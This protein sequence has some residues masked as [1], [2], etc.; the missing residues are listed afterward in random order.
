MNNTTTLLLGT[1]IALGLSSCGDQPAASAPSSGGANAPAAAVAPAVP[2]GDLEEIKPEFP[3]PLFQGTPIPPGN[4]PNLEKPDAANVKKSFMAP[5]GTTLLSKGKKVTSSDVAIIIPVPGDDALK[6]LTDGDAESSD[7]CFVE[8]APGPQWVQIDLEKT[9]SVAGIFAWH[10]H[11]QAVIVKG[12]VVQVSDDAEFKT[13]V[14]TI[15]N[16]DIDNSC[17]QGKGDDKAWVQTNHGRFFDGKGAKG[18]YVRLWSAGNTDDD[19]NRYIEI[20][21]YGSEAK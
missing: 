6:L 7:G 4:V 19:F 5:K 11:R 1:A 8:M 12:V 14:T 17:A 21:V 2:A 10:F 20:S 16:A 18:R 9:S 13:G 15:Y 3:K